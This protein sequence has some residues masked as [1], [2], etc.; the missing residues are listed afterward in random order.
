MESGNSGKWKQWKVEH[1]SFEGL[2]KNNGKWNKGTTCLWCYSTKT[3]I[4]RLRPLRWGAH[5][6]LVTVS[7]AKEHLRA[8]WSFLELFEPQVCGA[9]FPFGFCESLFLTCKF[10]ELTC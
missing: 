1:F 2:H 6:A 9:V 4:L 3:Q 10:D 8:F 5:N 7:V